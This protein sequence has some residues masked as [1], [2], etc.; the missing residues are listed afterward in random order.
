VGALSWFAA[1]R[2]TQALDGRDISRFLSLGK[3]VPSA[4]RPL[5]SRCVMLLASEAP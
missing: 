3:S 4:F 2:I 1:L 5:F